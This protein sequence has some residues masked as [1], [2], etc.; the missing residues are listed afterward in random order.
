MICWVVGSLEAGGRVMRQ[1]RRRWV[2]CLVPA[3]ALQAG[4]A[5]GQ[6]SASRSW[7][8]NVV[9]PQARSAAIGRSAAVQ[10][11]G[12][13]A[14]VVIRDQAATTMLEVHLR[15]PGGVRAESELLVPVPEGAVVRGFTFQ[16]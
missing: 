9:I 1:G 13:T 15:N 16:G 7:A 8:T 12:V 10:I 3:I 11:T 6:V 5:R 14:G 2:V 4:L